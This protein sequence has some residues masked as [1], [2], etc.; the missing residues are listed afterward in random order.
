[1]VAITPSSFNAVGT[2]ATS[3][4]VLY[5]RTDYNRLGTTA[6]SGINL[7]TLKTNET[8]LDV[9][10]QI[11]RQN[12]TNYYKF[13]LDGTNLKLKF[14]NLTNTSDVR[15]KIT[16]SKGNV[17][18]DNK[19]TPAQQVEFTRA[20]LTTGSKV[21]AGEYNVQV[22][23][24][25]TALKTDA[26]SYTLQLYSG[27]HFEKAYQTTAVAQN[28]ATTSIPTDNTEVFSTYDAQSY[29]VQQYNQINASI[30]N[31]VTIGWLSENLA[32]LE[33]KSR[34]TD[35]NNTN[36]FGLTFQKGENLK[37]AFNNTTNTSGLRFELLDRTG[38]VK[39]ADSD[40][41]D[42]QKAAFAKLTS[43]EGIKALPGQYV[44][45]VSY[46]TDADKSKTQN[47]N[48]KLYSG[49]YFAN[50][51]TTTASAESYNHALLAGN[52]PSS[53]NAQIASVSNLF[54]IS[55]GGTGADIF[56]VLST[57]A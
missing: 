2:Y 5:Q 57:F 40:G 10:G 11:T 21:K 51:Y 47:Y 26:Q 50:L 6:A 48:F 36:Y 39:L 23:Y 25:P 4:A 55:Q 19:G 22:T 33:V 52:L 14:Q 37:L 1:M 24:A 38:I 16:D 18:A 53:Y 31:N 34:L 20:S 56:T 32:A 49:T 12:S 44:I 17:I 9:T 35:V 8:Q 27:S 3:S 15:V 43:N 28:S 45:K 46:Q 42:E 41:T 54:D 30:I 7:G 13:T 29:G